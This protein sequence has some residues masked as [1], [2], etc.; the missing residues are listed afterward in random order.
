M[1]DELGIATKTLMSII[2]EI[3]DNDNIGRIRS[4]LSLLLSTI[5][6][7]SVSLRPQFLIMK[8]KGLWELAVCLNRMQRP[9]KGIRAGVLEATGV[10]GLLAGLERHGLSWRHQPSR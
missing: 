10:A 8:L 3:E 5:N 9:F 7:P 1:L 4:A 6:N 2:S